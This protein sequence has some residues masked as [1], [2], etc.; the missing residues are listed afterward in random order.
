MEARLI[1]AAKNCDVE[2]LETL[3]RLYPDLDVNWKDTRHRFHKAALHHATYL[4]HVET[5]KALLAHPRINVN[6]L[7]KSGYTSFADACNLGRVPVVKVLL[8]DPRVDVTLADKCGHIPLWYASFNGHHEVIE[9]LIASGRYLGDFKNLKGPWYGIDYTTIEIARKM[10]QTEAV[11]LLERF[12]ADPTLTRHELRVKLGMLDEVA[13]ELFALTVFLCDDLLQLSPA[14][15]STPNPA[16]S[17]ATRFFVIAK[18]LP[19]ELQMIL[20]HHTA[21]SKKQNILRKDS[22][23]AFKSLARTLLSS[24]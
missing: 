23:T 22:E 2:E 15:L 18:R 19:M 3:L 11:S 1:E 12:I 9:W 7:N 5:V 6:V 13:A 16:A 10:N 21:G 20:C 4:G 8:K 24:Q 14:P 17:A